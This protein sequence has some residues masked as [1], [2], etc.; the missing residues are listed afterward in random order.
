MDIYEDSSWG[1]EFVAICDGCGT[2]CG[3]TEGQSE[4][5]EEEWKGGFNIICGECDPLLNDF[6]GKRRH[7]T[8][9]VSY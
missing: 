4:Y 5:R 2:H 7:S 1:V 6:R 9:S 8:R 3:G